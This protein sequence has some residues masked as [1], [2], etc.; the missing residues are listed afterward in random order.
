MKGLTKEELRE[1]EAFDRE[2]ED[3]PLTKEEYDLARAIDRSIERE[4]MT[5]RQRK[6]RDGYKVYYEREKEKILAKSGNISV[7]A[8]EIDPF[9][10]QICKY[11]FSKDALMDSYNRQ[12]YLRRKPYSEVT[13]AE[14]KEL[15]ELE[16]Y[17]R[18]TDSYDSVRIV[19][20][21]FFTYRGWKQYDL[22]LMNPPF[23]NGAMHLLKA[24]ELQERGMETDARYYGPKGK[25]AWLKW[26]QEKVE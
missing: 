14:R 23:S 5:D 10:R 20:D 9:L 19:H 8:I 13:D 25:A 21:D 3:A 12:E 1:L 22:I 17:H 7:D 16:E 2:C 26:L 18:E 6:K 24:I 11:N 15:S 4:H